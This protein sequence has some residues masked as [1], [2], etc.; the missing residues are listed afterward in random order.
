MIS[1]PDL[2]DLTKA[3]REYK[4][5]QAQVVADRARRSK[6]LVV[7]SLKA[8]DRLAYKK[9]RATSDGNVGS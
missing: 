2:G 4:V 6:N 3:R 7:K 1:V 9:Q 5:H 8:Q